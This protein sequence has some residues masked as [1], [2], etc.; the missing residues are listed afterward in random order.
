MKDSIRSKL[1]CD[2]KLIKPLFKL[3]EKCFALSPL[4]SKRNHFGE[5]KFRGATFLDTPRESADPGF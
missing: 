2:A 4:I 1:C 3:F 5:L